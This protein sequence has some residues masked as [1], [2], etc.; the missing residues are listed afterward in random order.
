MTQEEG[1]V[2]A[3]MAGAEAGAD[4]P[5]SCAWCGTP[6]TSPDA[7]SC[8]SCGAAL[9]QRESIGDLAIPGL[10]SVDAAL[11]DY[12]KRPLHLRGPSPS[13]GAAPALIVGAMAGGP[14]GLAAIGGVAAVAAAE[15]LG[16]R[17]GGSGSL[18][19]VGRPSEV[20]LQALEHLADGSLAAKGETVAP[21]I[22]AAAAD[23]GRSVWRDLPGAAAF[24]TGVDPAHDEEGSGDGR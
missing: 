9:A 21:E 20:A 17:S 23:G 1:D 24:E 16:T 10:T 2:D 14:I 4:A 7:T 5:R 3:A 18:E 11:Q 15:F 12:D 8:A 22:D 19:Q 6:A 13:Q